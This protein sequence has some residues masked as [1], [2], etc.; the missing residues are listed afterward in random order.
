[1]TSEEIQEDI[2]RARDWAERYFNAYVDEETTPS[3]ILAPITCAVGF[4]EPDRM[5]VCPVVYRRAVPGACVTYR[6]RWVDGGLFW[7]GSL[8]PLPDIVSRLEVT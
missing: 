5:T 3:H 2:S 4:P 1:M 8:L 7:E 6:L